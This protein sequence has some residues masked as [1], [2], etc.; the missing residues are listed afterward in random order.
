MLELA[1]LGAGVMHSRSIEFAK[2]FSVPVHVRSSFTDRPGT[3]IVGR[4]EVE[5]RAVCGAALTKDEARVT[6]RGVPDVPGTS[7][8]IFSRIAEKNITVDMIVQNVGHRGAADISFTVPKN[9]LLL[10]LDAVQGSS[11]RLG[12]FQVI[13]DDQVSKV[14]VVG[15]GM[16][17]QS[18]VAHAMFGA[19]AQA[20][21]NMQMITTSEIKIS[22]LVGRE[23]AV[24][25]LRAVHEVFQFREGPAEAVPAVNRVPTHPRRDALDV[26]ARLQGIGM[27]ELTVE[28]IELDQKQGRV[29]IHGVPDQ[30]GVAARLFHEIAQATVFVT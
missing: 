18:G 14:S 29:T 20:G 22:A 9:E 8:N 7:L 5:G 25:A 4:P 27:E 13:H 12:Q 28:D 16:A 19:L 23:E 17:R 2:K 26:V 10:T 24:G 1:S 21:I 11:D 3:M 30:P 15:L 6:I